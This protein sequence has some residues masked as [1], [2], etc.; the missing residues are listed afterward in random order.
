M[1]ALK[2]KIFASWIVLDGNPS[3]TLV[4]Y[5]ATK[6]ILYLENQHQTSLNCSREAFCKLSN[7]PFF[8]DLN[9]FPSVGMFGWPTKKHP[10]QLTLS[11]TEVVPMTKTKVQG[12]DIL[13][14]GL[15]HR[16]PNTVFHR[17]VTFFCWATF[18]CCRFGRFFFFRDEIFTPVNKNYDFIMILKCDSMRVHLILLKIPGT[19]NNQF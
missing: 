13:F 14:Y 1:F 7:P 8:A 6:P 9:V 10:V 4:M 16:R 15:S 19:L 12:M 18:G 17:R 3:C 11:N 2:R 5:S